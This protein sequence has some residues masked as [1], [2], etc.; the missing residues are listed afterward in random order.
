MALDVCG[1]VYKVRI[2]IVIDALNETTSAKNFSAIW[3]NHLGSFEHKIS[4]TNN[5]V[6]L[7]TCRTTYINRIWDD[8]ATIDFYKIS[9]FNHES[10]AHAVEKYFK[11][12]KLKADLFFASLDKFREP[13]FL[14]LFCEVKNPNNKNKSEIEVR[15]E[16]ETVFDVF[17]LYLKTINDKVTTERVFLRSGEEFIKSH[18]I[19]IAKKMWEENTREIELSSF[20]ELMDGNKEYEKD[21]S[22]ADLLVDEGLLISR[23]NYHNKEYISFTYD[24]MAGYFIAKRILDESKD[25]AELISRPEFFNKL[26]RN[27]SNQLLHPLF[28]DILHSLSILLPQMKGIH[29]YALIKEPGDNKEFS[30]FNNQASTESVRVLFELNG[31][32][33]G[34]EEQK[35]ISNLLLTNDQSKRFIFSINYKSIS[36]INHPLNSLFFSQELQKLS[37]INRDKTWTEHVRKNYRDFLDITNGFANVLNGQRQYSAIITQKIHLMANY[38]QWI[39]SSTNRHL[40]D[41]CTRMFFYYGLRFPNELAEL[42]YKSLAIDDPYIWERLLAALYGVCLSIVFDFDG[43]R[44]NTEIIAR[45]SRKIFDLYFNKNAPHY[46]SHILARDYARR[47]V[48]LGIKLSPELLTKT[49]LNFLSY[50]WKKN[51]RLKWRV[52]KDKFHGHMSGDP[53]RMDFGNYTI[54]RLV[55]KGHGYETPLEKR[56]VRGKIYWRIAELGYEEDVFKPI[57]REVTSDF[58]SRGDR[59]PRR[60]IW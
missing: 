41:S 4:A 43:K 13:I 14:K 7:T 60:K 54:G 34:I 9:G 6:L 51:D 17:E 52:A 42:A 57:E 20:Y 53:I 38:L 24:L 29:L 27:I 49:E 44:Y 11:K 56:L 59:H 37:L 33:I 3:K 50:P 58:F 31:R 32:Y 46:S 19:K 21:K 55:D 39:L 10:V 2:P 30:E 15:I 8:S 47:I 45:I 22:K 28:E 35:L 36:V 1:E 12:Y 40:R 5:L 23:D 18:L 25:I 16:D 48:K 26:R